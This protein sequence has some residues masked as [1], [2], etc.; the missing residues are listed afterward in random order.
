[1]TVPSPELWDVDSPNLYRVVSRIDD[2]STGSTLDTYAT[3]TGF[4][5]FRFDADK[6]FYLNGRP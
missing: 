5:S 3:S 2:A 6:G 1:M 4:R